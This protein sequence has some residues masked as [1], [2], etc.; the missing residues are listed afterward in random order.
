MEQATKSDPRYEQVR[1]MIV[2]SA[3]VRKSAIELAVSVEA[4]IRAYAMK[5]DL[6]PH[7]FRLEQDLT[8][9]QIIAK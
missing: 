9:F 1:S 6:E 2:H 5:E 3:A 7:I 8:T 4:I